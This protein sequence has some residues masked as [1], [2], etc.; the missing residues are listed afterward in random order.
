MRNKIDITKL[1]V[2][3][4]IW[5]KGVECYIDVITSG[6]IF[7][8]TKKEG[9]CPM[10]RIIPKNTNKIRK[11]SGGVVIQMHGIW[12]KAS[13]SEL[14]LEAPPK[15]ITWSSDKTQLI[16]PYNLNKQLTLMSLLFEDK[17]KLFMINKVSHL[18]IKVAVS[19]ANKIVSDPKTS[20]LFIIEE[21]ML[22]EG[23]YKWYI[24]D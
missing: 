24:K 9:F 4:T 16:G 5:Y 19:A 22:E 20:E 10:L 8:A 1:T 21:M 13:A 2:D 14:S 11:S 12:V 17:Q 15:E 3:T 18:V 23:N 6:R 7:R